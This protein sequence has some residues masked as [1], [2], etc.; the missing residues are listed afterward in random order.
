MQNGTDIYDNMSVT[1]QWLLLAV[2]L[3]A[4]VIFV[5]FFGPKLLKRVALNKQAKSLRI[6]KEDRAKIINQAIAKIEEIKQQYQLGRMT[7]RDAAYEASQVTRLT[8]DKIMSHRT[9][10]STRYEAKQRNL[11]HI[12]EMLED[13][14][15]PEF[16]NDSSQS[17]LRLELFDKAIG[18]LRSCL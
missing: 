1:P 12:F 17:S 2:C 11:N 14:Y 16:S 9:L 18:V 3:S 7:N 13:A 8:F 15:P 5:K 6:S 4:L 10:Y